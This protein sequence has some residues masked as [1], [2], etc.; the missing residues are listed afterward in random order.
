MIRPATWRAQ[1]FRRARTTASSSRKHARRTPHGKDSPV[2][3]GTR[4]RQLSR[5]TPS[6]WRTPGACA[7]R[8]EQIVRSLPTIPRMAGGRWSASIRQVR[9]SADQRLP[10]NA[11]FRCD[12][13]KRQIAVKYLRSERLSPSRMR[14]DLAGD[15][16]GVIDSPKLSAQKCCVR[17]RHTC[18]QMPGARV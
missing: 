16:F 6:P 14:Y 5:S 7:W 2:E 15:L 13:V 11:G 3:R 9:L 1:I 17:D 10:P 12:A 8:D 18:M 4:P